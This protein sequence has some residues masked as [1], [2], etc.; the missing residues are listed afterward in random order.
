MTQ[1]VVWQVKNY[2]ICSG[3]LLL[4]LQIQLCSYGFLNKQQMHEKML[5]ETRVHLE[6]WIQSTGQG[7]VQRA[8]GEGEVAIA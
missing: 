4:H 3:E 7:G 1:Y 8:E 6:C 5:Y 2:R